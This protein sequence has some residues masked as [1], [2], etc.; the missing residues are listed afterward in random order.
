MNNIMHIVSD[1]LWVRFFFFIALLI[2]NY[3]FLG[4]SLSFSYVQSYFGVTASDATWLLR[5]FQSGTIITGI[6]GLVFVKWIGN[7]TLF[8]GSLFLLLIATVVS[9]TAN[10]F[11]ILLASRI[12]AGIAN[13]FVI[14]VSMQVYLS[15]YEG[16]MKIIGSIN[17]VAAALSGFCLGIFCNRIFTE[18]Y[19]W[20]FTYYLSVPALVTMIIF[21]FF[22]VP[23]GQKNMEIEDDWLSLIPFSI[24]IVSIFFVVLFREQYQG[25]SNIKILVSTV[26]AILSASLLILRGFIHKQP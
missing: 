11:N 3:N 19:G 9:F 22:F 18:D 14:S 26:L 24:L 1:K 21:S 7:R 20:Q 2:G 23:A 16:K 6:A 12:V 4:Q 15:T 8:I 13:G 25:L 10:S 17:T 5:G